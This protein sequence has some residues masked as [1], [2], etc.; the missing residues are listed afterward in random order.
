MST[1]YGVFTAI[2]GLASVLSILIRQFSMDKELTSE[3]KLRE[4]RVS[5]H[6]S[7]FG[8]ESTVPIEK[9]KVEESD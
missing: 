3:H 8:N 6:L 7:K 4:S 1:G 5:A 2:A 9:V